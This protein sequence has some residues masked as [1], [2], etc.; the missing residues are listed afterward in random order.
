[1]T[2]LCTFGKFLIVSNIKLSFKT[3]CGPNRYSNRPKLLSVRYVNK[4]KQICLAFRCF[5][6][7][8]SSQCTKTTSVFD[9]AISFR[10]VDVFRC[11]IQ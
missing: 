5:E 10:E 8:F 9:H 3:N 1:M 11:R 6:N 7:N 2:K 4:F